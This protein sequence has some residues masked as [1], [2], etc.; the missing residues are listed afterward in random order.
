MHIWKKSQL[1]YSLSVHFHPLFFVSLPVCLNLICMI[2]LYFIAI[3]RYLC[4]NDGSLV[5]FLLE[6]FC[7]SIVVGS[8]RLAQEIISMLGF[9]LIVKLPGHSLHSFADPDVTTHLHLAI[10][11]LLQRH[12]CSNNFLFHSQSPVASRV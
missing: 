11:L 8:Q 7:F 5:I 1:Y 2:L 4:C 6:C 9:H 10:I 12:S 3:F